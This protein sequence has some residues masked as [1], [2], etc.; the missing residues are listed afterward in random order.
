MIYLEDVEDEI[1]YEDIRIFD[2]S[3]MRNTLKKQEIVETIK[4]EVIS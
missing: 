1:E 2:L 4:D 3:A